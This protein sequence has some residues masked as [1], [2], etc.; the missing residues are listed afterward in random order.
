MASIIIDIPNKRS[1]SRWNGNSLKDL[2]PPA[3]LPVPSKTKA[4][5]M[6]QALGV[7]RAPRSLRVFDKKEYPGKLKGGS[8]N[9]AETIKKHAMWNTIKLRSVFII[10]VPENK[11]LTKQNFNI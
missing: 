11:L 3:M 7:N 5:F 10:Y 8:M 6:I 1:T 4:V 2:Q 9:M